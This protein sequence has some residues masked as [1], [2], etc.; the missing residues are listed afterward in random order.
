[1]VSSC[2]IASRHNQEPLGAYFE[3]KKAKFNDEQEKE[4]IICVR[5]QVG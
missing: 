2:Y 5:V 1:M 3:I 4:S